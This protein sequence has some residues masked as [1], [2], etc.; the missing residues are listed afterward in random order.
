IDSA[1][2]SSEQLTTL[3][4][5]ASKDDD[6]AAQSTAYLQE[7]LRL[8]ARMLKAF[9]AQIAKTDSSISMLAG[10]EERVLQIVNSID[11][12]A[13]ELSA[14]VDATSQ[15]LETLQ[16]ERLAEMQRRLDEHQAALDQRLMSAINDAEASFRDRLASVS[17]LTES[18]VES[19]SRQIDE[20]TRTLRTQVDQA[21]QSATAR[22]D[23]HASTRQEELTR[24]NSHV[25]E[26][27]PRANAILAVVENAQTRVNVLTQQIDEAGIQSQAVRQETLKTIA[28][29]AETR[30][31]LDHDL[32]E[33]ASRIDIT[34]ARAQE[35]RN[36]VQSIVNNATAGE[37]ELRQRLT[38]VHMAVRHIEKAE[39]TSQ[40]LASLLNH[41]APWEKIIMRRS[42]EN[43]GMPEPL[44]QLVDD[45]KHIVRDEMLR[46]ST[47]MRMLADRVE[48]AARN[49]RRETD[50]VHS[51]PATQAAR[52]II[53]DLT[54]PK[55]A[56]HTR[57]ASITEVI[58]SSL[59]DGTFIPS[60]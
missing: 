24:L 13:A 4:S 57:P 7:R 37:S 60:L 34:T 9:Q 28:Q 10:H 16:Q 19:L 47:S 30:A 3:L 6:R 46:L 36:S 53:D 52:A 12:R 1:N 5:A 40:R 44:A 48:Q 41:L 38:E 45:A 39:A 32:T 51:D 20:S 58:S 42:G 14:C 31:A 26:A 22:I 15:R 54:S 33:A 11:S 35:L 25:A 2:A 50:R 21:V 59:R 17:R 18:T 27:L 56:A 55:S 23:Q 43:A 29:C 49:D 8:A